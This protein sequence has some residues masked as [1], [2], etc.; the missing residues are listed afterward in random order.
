MNLKNTNTTFSKAAHSQRLK[1]F[2]TS[3]AL[4]RTTVILILASATTL[5]S[6]QTYNTPLQHVILVIQ[7][8][9]SPDNLFGSNPNF[10][11]GVDIATE[12]I[13]SLGQHIPLAAVEMTACYGLSHTHKDWEAMYD[14]GKMDG[15]DKVI[16]QDKDNSCPSIPQNPQFKYVD[17]GD[18]RLNPLRGPI[19]PY[20]LIAENWGFANYMFHTNQGPSF[21]AHQFLFSGTSAPSEYGENYYNYFAAE[22]DGATGGC[23]APANEKTVLIGPDGQEDVFVYPCFHHPTLAT[24]LDAAGVSWKYYSQKA[25]GIWSAPAASQDVCQPDQ[26]HTQCMGQDWTKNMSIRGVNGASAGQILSDISTNCNL[27]NVSWVIPEAAWGDH[28]HGN[29]GYGPSWVADIVNA[30]GTSPCKNPDGSNYWNTTAVLVTWDEWGGWYDHVPPPAV[31]YLGGG[32]NGKQYVYGFRVPLLVASAYSPYPGYV[33][34]PVSNPLVCPNYYCHDF[35]SILNFIEYAFGSN[36]QSL[37]TIG[38]PLWPYADYYALDAPPSCPTC[39]YS[40]SDFFEFNRDPTAP[41]NIPA[42][43]PASFF[44]NFTGHHQDADDDDDPTSPS[45]IAP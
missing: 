24:V 5:A 28:A 44:I 7:E 8:N 9:R 35:G 39:T 12:G 4:I 43:L 45:P 1:P 29:K 16:V 17:N 41:V 19:D 26:D 14:N 2:C 25:M 21:A 38:N 22:V 3:T 18:N 23:L 32:G 20:F 15:A 42:P 6:A 33:S 36:G 34:G 40:L 37:G 13:N 30:V 10:L 31:G 11:P 27:N